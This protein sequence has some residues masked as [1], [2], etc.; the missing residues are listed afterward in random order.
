[1]TR[2]FVVAAEASQSLCRLYP[3]K[4]TLVGVNG[5]LGGILRLAST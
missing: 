3:R 2:V 1:M 5:D 4:R